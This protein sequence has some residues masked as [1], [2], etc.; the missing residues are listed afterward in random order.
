MLLEI[1]VEGG[2]IVFPENKYLMEEALQEQCLKTFQTYETYLKAILRK[3]DQGKVRVNW[4]E[5]SKIIKTANYRT[6]RAIEEYINLALVALG[7]L[8]ETPEGAWT[9]SDSS[10]NP[11]WGIPDQNYKSLFMGK[12]YFP[13]KSDIVEYGNANWKDR[14]S[15][16]I[17]RM[18]EV[19]EKQKIC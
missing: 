16:F 17:F 7:V 8:T 1:E 2:T 12:A 4:F 19:L 15:W 10:M 18:M 5:Y 9:F 6:G 13:E 14:T 11:S 3:D